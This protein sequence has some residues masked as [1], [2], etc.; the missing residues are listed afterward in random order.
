[1][2]LHLKFGP[3]VQKLEIF[4]TFCGIS[5]LKITRPKE[6]YIFQGEEGSDMMFNTKP[7]LYFSNDALG[8]KYRKVVRF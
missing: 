5:S 1:M 4:Q 2:V 6:S 7:P 3:S 8:V